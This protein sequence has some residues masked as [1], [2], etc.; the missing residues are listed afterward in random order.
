MCVF[1]KIVKGE[2]P[3]FKI[4]ETDNILAF[5]DISQVTQGHTL[6]IPK[7]HYENVF[8]LDFKAASEVFEAVPKISRMLKE[9]LKFEALNVLNNN[10]ALAGQSVNHFH[11]HLIPRYQGD[12]LLIRFP[13]REPDFKK[14]EETLEKVVGNKA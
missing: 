12:E 3:C 14:L 4:Y 6:I 5:L 11:I 8:E 1:C 2:I 13:E 10:G 9:S 7:K